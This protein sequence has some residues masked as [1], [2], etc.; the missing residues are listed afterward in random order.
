MSKKK[1]KVLFKT[2]SL[3]ETGKRKRKQREIKF[4]LKPPDLTEMVNI[5]DSNKGESL[6]QVSQIKKRDIIEQKRES[7]IDQTHVSDSEDR[8]VADYDQSSEIQ[9]NDQKELD[10]DEGEILSP[11]A[12]SYSSLIVSYY[13]KHK[14]KKQD[15]DLFQVVENNDQQIT[16]SFKINPTDTG[17][18]VTA[19]YAK[20]TALE[21][22]DLWNSITDVSNRINGP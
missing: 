16:I 22:I 21:R 8:Q 2:V 3:L 7:Q 6:E 20:C 4:S 18:F 17:S 5:D 9:R 1:N 15:C 14:I 12:E 13:N 19:V 11:I 10:I